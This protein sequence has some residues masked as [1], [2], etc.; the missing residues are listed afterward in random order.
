MVQKIVRIANLCRQLKSYLNW[1]N[2]VQTLIL[3]DTTWQDILR[4]ALNG[5]AN[6]R[7]KRF[8]S[9]TRSPYDVLTTITSHRENWK[10]WENFQ[11]S[12][13]KSSWNVCTWQFL[14]GKQTGTS[15]QKMGKSLRQTFGPFDLVHSQHEWLQ[16]IMSCWKYITTLQIWHRCR[17]PILLGILKTQNRLREEFYVPSGVEVRSHKL[18]QEA[19][20]SCEILGCRP[21][22]GLYFRSWSLGFGC[23]SITFFFESTQSM[24][25]LVEWWTL[26]KHSNERTKKQSNTSEDFGWTNVDYVTSSPTMRHVS[27]THRVALD[28]LF[29]RINL[30]QK[31]KSNF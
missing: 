5:T 4:N 2:L 23:W 18:V 11:K 8:S 25:Q 27:R 3:G 16:T 20:V 13:F 21:M 1:R 6:W 24:E 14:V 28:R 10:L 12:A 29:D 26:W 7:M 31:S 9:C 15:S 30:D 22:H 19:N 17:I